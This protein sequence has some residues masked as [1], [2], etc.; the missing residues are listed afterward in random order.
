MFEAFVQDYRARL[1]ERIES[2][3][4]FFFPYKRILC[5]GQRA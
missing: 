2:S 4:P 1:L 5:W 3:R